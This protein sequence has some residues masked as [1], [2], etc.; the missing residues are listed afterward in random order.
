MEDNARGRA[1]RLAS[2]CTSPAH[3]GFRLRNTGTLGRPRIV[4]AVACLAL[5]PVAT[6]DRRGSRPWAVLL[7]LWV[8]LIAYEVVRYAEARARI[9]A[10]RIG[11]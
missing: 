4:T 7:A 8:A 11:H 9:R 10:E 2:R 1:V 5:I 6:A 3:V